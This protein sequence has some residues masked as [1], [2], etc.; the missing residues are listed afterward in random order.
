[1]MSC[2]QNYK[3]MKLFI[4]NFNNFVSKFFILIKLD[5]L[6]GLDDE[7]FVRQ[8]VVEE[9]DP[10]GSGQPT[11][12][13]FPLNKQPHKIYAYLL[14]V[15]AYI[16]PVLIKICLVAVCKRRKMSKSKF[17]RICLKENFRCSTERKKTNKKRIE[18]KRK[19]MKKMSQIKIY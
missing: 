8:V 18:S 1:M 16:T 3:I 6:V 14:L 5:L 7:L 12:G 2:L 17:M 9:K 19:K 15:P 4:T 13:K 11:H 10:R